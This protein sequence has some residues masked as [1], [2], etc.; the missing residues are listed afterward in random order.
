MN[1]DTQT[2]ARRGR[3]ATQFTPTTTQLANAVNVKVKFN[4]ETGYYDYYMGG[5]LSGSAIN[6]D[7]VRRRVMRGQLEKFA[8]ISNNFENPFRIE[9]TDM[10]GTVT[11]EI[12]MCNK[13]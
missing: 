1:T 12:V 10:D 6:A 5:K 9:T 11:T 7:Y 8:S 3:P 2:A 4:P 13:K